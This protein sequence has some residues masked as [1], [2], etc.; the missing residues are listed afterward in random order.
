MIKRDGAQTS[1]WQGNIQSYIPTGKADRHAKYDVVIIGGGITGVTTGLLLQEAGKKCLLVEAEELGFGTTGGTTAHLNTLLDTPYYVI[2]QNFGEEHAKHVAQATAE[3]LNLI[4]S[5]VTRFNIDCGFQEASAYLYAQDADQEKEL[6]KIRKSAEDAGLNIGYVQEIPV[7]MH[8]TKAIRAAGQAKFN[9]LEYIQGIAQAFEAAG[10][11]ILQQTRVINVTEDDSMKV[12]TTAGIFSTT[13]VVY[14]T[15]I[16]PGIN[17]LHLRCA[18]YRSYAMAVTLE[19]EAYPYDLSYDLYDPYHYYRTQI[20]NGQYYLIA[21][22][23]DHKTGTQENTDQCFRQ[24]EAHVRKHFKVKEVAYKWSSQY[25]EPTD[26]LPYIGYLPGYEDHVFV[27]SG[28]GGNGM[29]YGTVSAQLLKCIIMKETPVLEKLF[30]PNRIKPVAG[31]TNF[32]TH[33]TDVIKE[34][35]G[36]LFSADELKQ[37]ADLAPGEGKL[38][39]YRDRKVALYR[40]EEG[41]LH[42]LNPTCTHMKCDVKWN[43][44][45]RSW[46][47]PCHG[48]RYNYDGKVITGPADADL[49]GLALS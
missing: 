21:G 44:S 20:V 19:D 36:K 10:G 22:G 39:T 38:V 41:K 7:N 15:H 34:F 18:P 24:L 49:E 16:P 4:R 11:V 25:Y 30:D 2:A 14:A 46:D 48:A 26:G 8:Y 27:A 29:T 6:E 45:E 28:F 33:N 35:F 42:A 47:C 40:N 5:N 37:L 12:A 23:E 43:Q 3:A 1:L 13:D 31:F 17:L 32:V 9:P